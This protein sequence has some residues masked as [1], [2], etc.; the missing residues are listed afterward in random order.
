MY[1]YILK[2]TEDKLKIENLWK[3]GTT[4]RTV[5]KLQKVKFK[6]CSKKTVKHGVICERLKSF[7]KVNFKIVQ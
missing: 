6:I 5:I 1:M 3:Y 7:V 4:C 2:S